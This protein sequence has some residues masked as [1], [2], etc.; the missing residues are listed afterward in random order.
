MSLLL[1]NTGGSSAIYSNITDPDYGYINSGNLS[2]GFSYSFSYLKYFSRLNSTYYAQLNSSVARAINSFNNLI[3]VANSTSINITVPGTGLINQLIILKNIQFISQTSLNVTFNVS[4]TVYNA[5][6]DLSNIVYTDS[7]INSTSYL[8][9]LTSGNSYSLDKLVIVPK[10]ASNTVH[11]FA[12]GVAVVNS[13]SFYSNIPSVSIPGYG[14]PA[15]IIV[16]APATVLASDIFNSVIEVKNINPDIGQDFITNYWITSGDESQNHSSGQQTVYVGANSSTNISVVLTAPLSAGNYRL[17]A[18]T[19]WVGGTATAF[20]TFEVT[21]VGGGTGG[22]TGGGGGGGVGAG[23]Q[24]PTTGGVIAP[25]IVACIAPY[26]LFNGECC[27]DSN[28]NLLCDDFE[29]A[30]PEIPIVDETPTITGLASQTDEIYQRL[31]YSIFLFIL[32]ALL[33]LSW[34][35]HYWT[36]R[37]ELKSRLAARSLTGMEVYTLAGM[38]FGIV[39]DIIVKDN[40]IYGLA[41]ELDEKLQTGLKRVL[42]RYNYVRS[43]KDVVLIDSYCLDYLLS[44]RNSFKNGLSDSV[45]RDPVAQPG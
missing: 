39:K 9:N 29:S 1:F 25:P 14:G 13:Q 30:E 35:T 40:V 37:K 27:L 4:V 26:I 23:G 42:V 44:H 12:Q 19:S 17:R 32:L 3:L 28:S 18:L 7:D 15:D 36:T 8:F 10:A 34:L 5:G 20:D 16:Y 31:Y 11:T 38:R 45:V 6:N 2:A 22:G 43:V 24:P 33:L 21:S 41:V